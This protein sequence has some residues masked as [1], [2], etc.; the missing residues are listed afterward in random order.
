M[1]PNLGGANQ[2][3]RLPD[4]RYFQVGAIRPVRSASR[5]KTT[6]MLTPTLSYADWLALGNP[7]ILENYHEH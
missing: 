6:R 3:S 1:A 4:N 5:S 2:A 7:P